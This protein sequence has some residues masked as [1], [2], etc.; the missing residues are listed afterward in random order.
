MIGGSAF[1]EVFGGIPHGATEYIPHAMKA[2]IRMGWSPVLLQP[3]GKEPGCIL[4]TVT[5]KKADD[6][7]RAIAKMH[8]P[9]AKLDRIRH[10]CGFKHVIEAPEEI[11]IDADGKEHRKDPARNVNNIYKQFVKRYGGANLGLHLGRSHLMAVDVDTPEERQ[12]FALSWGLNDR[13]KFPQLPDAPPLTVESPGSFDVATQTWLHHGGGHWWFTL[14]DNWPEI[15]GK[16]F[17]GPG[18]WAAM[19]GEAFVL[20]PPSVRLE[21]PYK[22]TGADLPAPDWL[23]HQVAGA[24]QLRDQQAEYRANV[25][26]PRGG[27]IDAWSARTSWAS[28]LEPRGWTEAG[29]A[30]SCGCPNWTG[31]D[32]HSNPKSATAHDLGCSVFS[33]D[34]GWGPLHIWTDHPP[35]NLPPEGTVTK[36]QYLALVEHD[37]SVARAL[38]SVGV[39]NPNRPADA[40][41]PQDLFKGASPP[42]PSSPAGDEQPSRGRILDALLDSNDLNA[43]PDSVPLIDGVLDRNTV[44]VLAG[45]FG[46]YKSFLA[47]D[48]AACLAT[49][50]PWN[51]HAVPEAVPV[52]YVAAEGATGVKKRRAAWVATQGG[53]PRGMLT[54]LPLA[55][56]LNQ[57]DE[58]E[59]LDVA[60]KELGARFLVLDTMHKVTPGMK[61][62]DNSEIGQMLSIVDLIKERNNV[63]V[64]LVHHTGHSGVRSRGGSSIEDDADTVFV[65]Q[66]EGESRLPDNPRTLHHRK[67]KD[68]ELLTPLTL[69]FR[70]VDGTKSGVLSV[71]PFV[72]GDGPGD[73]S[74]EGRVLEYVTDHPG[75]SQTS[76][77]TALG[78]HKRV[79]GP[80]LRKLEQ[81]QVVRVD[82]VGQTM[83]HYP[84]SPIF[85]VTG[86]P[87]RTGTEPV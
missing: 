79:L 76:I 64:L 26:A 30:H 11:T 63:T 10:A 52:L 5:A 18:G 55:A 43:I 75:E 31:P 41:R 45:K 65:V 29:S 85:G 19:Y 47:I 21:G 12:A 77:S 13:S 25:L 84:I 72:V 70:G 22:L 57:G 3:G 39:E 32:G 8:N 37:G 6:E 14:P 82:T 17:K 44:A 71:D 33:T 40:F 51:G 81:D 48:W 87:V 78:M 38:T 9:S 7:A 35:D 68:D 34:E 49:G 28:L 15:S 46:T 27:P 53:I 36:V 20:V 16:V 74:L 69:A 56:R 1:G 59:Q 23:L 42:D 58:V 86:T 80:L 54:I 73:P 50:K 24:A 66:I 61:E 4:A 67:T 83:R 62:N 60:L 2:A